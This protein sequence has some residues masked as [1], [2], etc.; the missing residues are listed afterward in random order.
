VKQTNKK[1]SIEMRELGTVLSGG[2]IYPIATSSR[3][4]C[5]ARDGEHCVPLQISALGFNNETGSLFTEEEYATKVDYY[6]VT[7]SA[8]HTS[9]CITASS[10]MQS[11]LTRV[12]QCRVE[13]RPGDEVSIKVNFAGVFYSRVP[14]GM[15]ETDQPSA[16]IRYNGR[17]DGKQQF[18]VVSND[19]CA[20][21]VYASDSDFKVN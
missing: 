12:S 13:V 7:I 4:V 18:S 1:A 15:K 11:P 20:F 17:V 9:V 8:E 21:Y 19:R 2:S 3:L 5:A 6:L 10:P 16:T 14:R